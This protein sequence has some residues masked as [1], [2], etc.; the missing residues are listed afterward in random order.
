MTTAAAA[1]DEPNQ[2]RPALKD[3]KA[4]HRI[5]YN[6]YDDHFVYVDS[7]KYN[8]AYPTDSF[9]GAI[10]LLSAVDGSD[11]CPQMVPLFQWNVYNTT[12]EVRIYI[13]GCIKN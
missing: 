13:I 3:L 9:E 1:P 2:Q 4:L 5:H 6:L 11:W 8:L 10:G 7:S 12:S